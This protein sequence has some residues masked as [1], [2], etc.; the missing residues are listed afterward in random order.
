MS[1]LLTRKNSRSSISYTQS[2]KQGEN[3]PAYTPEY[4]KILANAGIQMYVHE[5]GETAISDDCKE[6]CTTLLEA[7]YEPP[8][9]SLFHGDFFWV[10]LNRVRS[11]NEARVVR[12]ITPYIV[13]S[14]EHLI[15]RGAS[16]LSFLI[17][18]IEGEWSKCIPLAGPQLTPD[19]AV[20]LP[21]SVF[22]DS[23]IAKLKYYTAPQKPTMF[24]KNFYFP[25]LL[26]EAKVR[27]T[28]YS[29]IS[30]PLIFSAARTGL[31]LQTG[32]TLTAPVWQLMRFF[33][34]IEKQKRFVKNLDLSHEQRNFIER[35]LYFQSHMTIS[36]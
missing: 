17:E 15:T 20:G 8:E 3:P 25:F 9:N 28:I 21:P 18:E 27:P 2:V 13:P 31:I 33:N 11:R 34:F 7:D 14:A 22:T 30:C 36:G 23:E 10:T 32:R 5:V 19:F 1:Q 35:F 29:S 12:D 4:E 6:L 24:T 26:C 16:G